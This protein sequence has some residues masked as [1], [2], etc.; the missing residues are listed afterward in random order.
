VVLL[1]SLVIS[2]RAGVLYSNGPID[3]TVTGI[4]FDGANS[5]DISDSFVL[6]SSSI[7]TGLSNIGIWVVS[8][9]TFTSLDWVISTGPDG[10]GTVEGSA[11]NATPSSATELLPTT[12]Y[13]GG[14]DFNVYNVSFSVPD[15]NLEA[16]TFYLTF[17]NAMGSDTI[18]SIFW[19]QNGGPS[20]AALYMDGDYEDAVGSS[21][22]EID[23]TVAP[24]PASLI[25]FG[26]GFVAMAATKI[27]R[28]VRT[29]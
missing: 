3:G 11:A 5:P 25:L 23:G 12:S 1:L 16:G 4:E 26:I 10:T 18:A 17:A 21:S 6:Q 14:G 27:I 29:P 20:T 8:G 19:D 13:G 28:T 22:F 9:D 15:L 24:E 2:A 7:V